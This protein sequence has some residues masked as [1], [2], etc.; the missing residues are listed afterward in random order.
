MAFEESRSST[1][2]S[3]CLVLLDTLSTRL[4]STCL[5]GDISTNRTKVSDLGSGWRDASFA[6]PVA[7]AL[8]VLAFCSPLELAGWK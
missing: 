1:D 6:V 8:Q 4:E 3:A 2:A 7:G 5:L